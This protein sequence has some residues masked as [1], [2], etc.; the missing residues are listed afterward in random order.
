MR[1]CILQTRPLFE[2]AFFS[3]LHVT[4]PYFHFQPFFYRRIFSEFCH[5]HLKF[6][7]PFQ[8]PYLASIFYV[9]LLHLSGSTG[10]LRHLLD[11]GWYIT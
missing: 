8:I 4:A 1:L 10:S 11:T 6:L 5:I 7:L 3:H 9:F 2:F